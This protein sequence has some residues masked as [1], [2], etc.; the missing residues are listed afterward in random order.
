MYLIR[1]SFFLS[2]FECYMILVSAIRINDVYLLQYLL[3]SRNYY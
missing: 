1:R 2:A 3:I